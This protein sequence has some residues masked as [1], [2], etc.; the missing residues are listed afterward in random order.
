MNDLI[1]DH[2]YVWHLSLIYEPLN[3]SMFQQQQHVYQ[4]YSDENVIPK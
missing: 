2:P 3:Q 4:N 1:F